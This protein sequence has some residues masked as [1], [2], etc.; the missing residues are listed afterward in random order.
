MKKLFLVGVLAIGSLS[1]AANVP[2]SPQ[3]EMAKVVVQSS[4]FTEIAT[5]ELPTAITEAVARTYP[6][7]T[8][9][10]AYV[11]GEKQYKLEVALKDG[12]T[13]T[14]YA[15]ENGNWLEL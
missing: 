10:K 9:G 1:V 7:A 8:I 13:G 6:T 2:Q 15:D 4:E 3:D 11:N 12:T 5:S 14:L